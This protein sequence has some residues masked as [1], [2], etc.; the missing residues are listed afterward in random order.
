MRTLIVLL[1]LAAGC[2]DEPPSIRNLKYA[3]NAAV[4]GTMAQITGSVDYTD[5]DND[6][7]QSQVE[8]IAPSGAVTTASPSPIPNTGE[9]VVGTVSFTIM[10]TPM[11]EGVWHFNVWILDLQGRPSNRLN[12]PIRVSPP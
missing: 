5:Q 9:G 2:G 6:I 12:G 7:S 10:F 4:L 11:E 8:L 1:A 3:P